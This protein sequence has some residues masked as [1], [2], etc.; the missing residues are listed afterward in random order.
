[1]KRT[2]IY[3]L[4]SLLLLLSFNTAAQVLDDNYSYRDIEAEFV[5]ENIQIE[6]REVFFNVLKIVNRSEDDRYV[7][8]SYETPLGW[9][10][11][12]N[13]E[14]R[15]NVPAGDSIFMPMR[16]SA[17][18]N[19]K[20]EIGY[21]ITASLNT[22]G[23]DPITTAYC[24]IKVPRSS[25][26]NLLPMTRVSYIDQKTQKG[27]FAFKI[28]NKGNVDEV[29]NLEF[30][31]TH[32][33]NIPDEVDNQYV[34]E[35]SI[36]AKTDTIIDYEV[37]VED[38]D[39]ERS[40]Y[41]IDLNGDTENESFNTTFWF[42]YLSNSFE[43]V[44]P[45]GQVPLVLNLNM[46]NLFSEY[47]TTFSGRV[48]GNILLRNNREL[49]YY[50]YK[51]NTRRSGDL[52][53]TSRINLKYNSDRL[54][55]TAG[56][57]VSFNL[58]TGFGRG[59][60]LNY[61]LFPNFEMGGKYSYHIHLPINNYGLNLGTSV[62]NSKVTT[63]LEYST[64]G[65]FDSESA[66]AKFSTRF[67]LWD[68]HS[69]RTDLAV[70]DFSDQNSFL[71]DKTGYHH[72]LDYKGEF[73]KLTVHLRNRY[74]SDFY[75]G[76]F[77]GGNETRGNFAL[78]LKN[79]YKFNLNLISSK[80][81]PRY[82]LT[83][84]QVSDNYRIRR[85]AR[86]RVGKHLNSEFSVYGE[87]SYDFYKANRFYEA[88]QSKPFV[89]H[90]GYLRLGS[91]LRFD[92]YSR[93]SASIKGG[94]SFVDSYTS[95]EHVSRL[96]V[97]EHQLQKRMDAFNAIFDLT[98][99]SRKWGFFFKYF[100]GPYNG[101]QY[102]NYF[103]NGSYT[104]MLRLMPYYRHFV[105]KDIIELDTRL[106]Y[107]YSID[108]NTHRVNW[109]NELTFHLD[110]GLLLKLV[111]TFTFQSSKE[112]EG[113]IMGE[114][115]RYTY[116]NTY[117]ETRFEKRFD[118]NQPRVKYHDL[119]VNLYKDLNGNLEKDYNEPGVSNV[120]VE[121]EKLDASQIDSI[122][123]DY[124]ASGN[125][126][127]N[128]LL[129][130]MKGTISYENIP[131]GLYK[132]T[133]K[134][135][136]GGTGKFTPDVQEVITHIN[137]D[138]EVYIPFLERNKIFGKIILNRSKLSNLGEIDIGNVKITA[139]DSK[140]RTISTLTDDDGNFSLYAPS[141][142]L[143]T[144]S[145]N[146]IFREN[147]DLRKNDYKVQLNGYRQFEVN[148]IF[149]EKRRRINF[150]PSSDEQESKVRSVK[151]TNLSGV[152]KDES[153]LQPVR[154]NIE[155]V[156]NTT[157]ATIESTT[158]DRET[159]RFSTSFMTGPNYSMIVD[160]SG[161]WLYS[162]RLD[163]DE[164]LTIQDVEKEVLLKNIM[165]GSKIELENLQF[166][167]GSKEIPNEAYPEIDRLIEQLK[168]NQNVRIQI[169]GHSDALETLED[170][171]LSEERAKAV[172]RY[173]MQNGFSNI[174]YVGHKDNKPV[175]PNDSEENRMKNRRVEV[176]VVD[177]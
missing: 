57:R 9:N 39:M 68:G 86:F 159:G 81:K 171:S 54:A 170:E 109:G 49:E 101:N 154:A 163:L 103:Y 52:L 14:E 142:D 157:G 87:P 122:P 160:A 113:S 148:F 161:Y 121:I 38:P 128:R 110:Y 69:L 147:F 151:R 116:S 125:L 50:Y 35:L 21:S 34:T 99:N 4:G 42:R 17:S 28:E 22:R 100:H 95:P 53:E 16:A 129:S 18:K 137:Q 94:L 12:T 82:D 27:S 155:I 47:G 175:A 5:R 10:L 167:A 70:S 145:V 91:I 24:F 64:D 144:V 63:T 88:D 149:D 26:V 158:S 37:F 29:V 33:L 61:K 108:Y 62:L 90:S 115:S 117:I 124:E 105:Y 131:E 98:Y 11:I 89:T 51:Y 72:H 132:I 59:L 134:D 75:Y 45:E 31:S 2:F 143:Y 55:L 41:R 6:P 162:E 173:M 156:D 65:R 73:D 92:R 152:V 135:V 48:R 141:V 85:N 104:Q 118:W 127:T 83:E 74:N 130:G 133:I 76:G 15:I 23:G 80:R 153:T 174:E 166:E 46:E 126:V 19:V 119:N 146:N 36:P 111:G 123:G 43:Y 168:E 3:G 30:T 60:S 67:R 139:T 150:T 77:Y 176:I 84:P 13:S 169:A 71:F 1:M 177:K 96:S 66:L 20:G 25:H 102:F 136:G 165:I 107:M 93:L 79:G 58:R 44:K 112:E 106:N 78:P 32:N 172:A 120:L 56:D 97:E 164:M 7:N 140:G 138:R 114:S 8:L 40:L